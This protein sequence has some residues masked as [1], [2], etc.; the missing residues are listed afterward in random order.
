MGK[1]VT[2]TQ[3]ATKTTLLNHVN[4]GNSQSSLLREPGTGT[5]DVTELEQRKNKTAHKRCRCT[6]VNEGEHQQGLWLQTALAYYQMPF[7]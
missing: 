6:H 3:V 7:P 2:T 1:P 5:H 4:T